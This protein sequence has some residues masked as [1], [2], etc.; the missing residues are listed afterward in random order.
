VGTAAAAAAGLPHLQLE[1]DLSIGTLQVDE[2]AMYGR[3]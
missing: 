2:T 1:G 3:V